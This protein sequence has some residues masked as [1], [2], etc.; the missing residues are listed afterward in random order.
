MVADLKNTLMFSFIQR[1]A[2]ML[3]Q[4]VASLVIARILTPEEIGIFSIGS[5]VVSFLHVVRDL[6]VSGYVIQERELTQER[7][8]S[9]QAIVWITSL[10]LA[11]FLALISGPVG[12]FYKEPGVT[13]ILR[14]LAI[15]S[16]FLPIGA[17][18]MALMVRNMQF[19][20]LAILNTTVCLVHNGV[21]I[22]LGLLGVGFASLAWGAVAGGVASALG[23][24]FF[25]QENQPWVPGLREYR[26]VLS[27]C[28][29][30][31]ASSFLY[32]FGLGGPELIC[33][34]TLGFEA[35]AYFSKA[36]GAAAIVL[37]SL[38]ESITPVAISH[39]AKITR[40]DQ[41]AKESY[42][43]A[44][45][46]LSVIV[47][48]IFCSLAIMAEPFIVLLY[49]QQW[50]PAVVPLRIACIG[51]ACI[52]MAN[53]AGSVLVGSGRAGVN[54]RLH[55]IFQPTKIVLVMLGTSLDLIG[56][57]SA[58]VIAD[59]ALSVTSILRVNSLVE[60]SAAEC[61]KSF[62][63]SIFITA[64]VATAGVLLMGALS[65]LE[66]GVLMT[67]L[68]GGVGVVGVWIVALYAVRHPLG[69]DLKGIIGK[70]VKS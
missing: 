39:F 18:T 31:S 48:P 33:G 61:W 43:K 59:V 28:S 68:L 45:S 29:K 9:A 64:A 36:M 4:L 70:F 54:M 65:Y 2:T 25:R 10:C 30:L 26:R 53:V 44:L 17:I 5:V 32:E 7:L 62:S 57:I 14:V 15:N 42:L 24:L 22:L 47:F 60:V 67:N 50:V 66:T 37:R 16:L 11:V 52:T 1:N 46:Y 27:A 23:T 41:G 51:S 38:V 21:S 34:R 63:H 49:G 58:V 35:V 56:V 69:G 12:V 20:K 8:R 40:A 55:A 19:G 13:L 3:I 6:G